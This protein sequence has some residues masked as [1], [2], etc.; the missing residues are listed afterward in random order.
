MPEWFDNLK[1]NSSLPQESISSPIFNFCCLE[2]IRLGC[3]MQLR[4]IILAEMKQSVNESVP[5]IQQIVDAAVDRITVTLTGKEHL[6]CEAVSQRDSAYFIEQNV[7]KVKFDKQSDFSQFMFF[8]GLLLNNEAW[9]KARYYVDYEAISK[10]LHLFPI[11]LKAFILVKNSLFVTVD[12]LALEHGFKV[13]Y[14]TFGVIVN[15]NKQENG[16]GYA[17]SM[18]QLAIAFPRFIDSIQFG[19]IHEV[20]P[21]YDADLMSSIDTTEHHHHKKKKKG[22]SK[23]PEH[24]TQKRRSSTISGKKK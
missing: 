1:K 21:N 15:H 9:S 13:F 17:K 18:A 3:A 14:T 5:G 7:E 12:D 22:A 11:A 8:I 20:F 4:E 6:I 23:K 10:N 2:M 24:H 16:K 19:W